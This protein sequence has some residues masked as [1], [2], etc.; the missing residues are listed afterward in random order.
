MVSTSARPGRGRLDERDAAVLLGRDPDRQALLLEQIVDD[1]RDRRGLDAFGLGELRQ[2]EAFVADDDRQRRQLRR[3]D[4][5]GCVLAQTAAQP[6]DGETQ[7]GGQ[8]GATD[9]LI[10]RR[11]TLSIAN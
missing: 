2:R 6:H 11:H 5:L 3:G 1:T 7:L 9:A 10:G 4:V 8:L